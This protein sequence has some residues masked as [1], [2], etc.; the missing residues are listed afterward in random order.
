MAE[1]GRDPAGLGLDGRL[2][3]GDASPEDWIEETAA[4]R[5]MGAS[6]LS[7]ENRRAGLKR[8]ATI[9]KMMSRFKEAVEF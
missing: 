5:K 7:I 9:S 4:W 6:H 2:K 3:T 1:Y 8:P